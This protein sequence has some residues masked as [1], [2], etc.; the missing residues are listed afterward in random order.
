MNLASAGGTLAEACQKRHYGA[1]FASCPGRLR[2]LFEEVGVG[3]IDALVVG[4]LGAIG[5]GI[6]D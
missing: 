1:V 2:G 4:E 6:M 5:R 3:V